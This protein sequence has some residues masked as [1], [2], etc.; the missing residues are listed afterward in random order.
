M[1]DAAGVFLRME[2]AVNFV[3]K[4][5]EN[6]RLTARPRIFS[7][8]AYF[9]TFKPAVDLCEIGGARLYALDFVG[10]DV[11]YVGVVDT[12]HFKSYLREDPHDPDQETEANPAV[13][14]H[15]ADSYANSGFPGTVVI[16]PKSIIYSLNLIEKVSC[17][18][19]SALDGTRGS[20]QNVSLQVT[21]QGEYV[22]QI[23]VSSLVENITT[24]VPEAQSQITDVALPDPPVSI[25]P[26]S[27]SVVFE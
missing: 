5:E 3:A 26:T 10:P 22:L 17:F 24:G 23:G 27:W 13:P 12:V 14:F 15:D 11:G 1:F 18:Q 4:L 25:I 16:P 19:E 6:E 7:R 20:N 9:A 8:R 2:G 21:D